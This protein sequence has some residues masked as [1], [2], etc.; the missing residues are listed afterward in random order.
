MLPE[1][2]LGTWK[3]KGG[4]EPLRRGIEL[5][6]FHIDTAEMYSTEGVVGEAVRG[7]RDKVFV[8]SKVLG[9]HLRYDEVLRAA[10]AGLERAGLEYFDLYQI[11]YPNRGV[12]IEETMRAMEALVDSGKVRYI[13]VSNFSV[14]ELREAQAAM[15]RHPVVA[16][17]VIYNLKRRGI[18]SDLMPYCEENDVTV[19]AYTP[20]AGGSLRQGSRLWGGRGTQ[21]LERIAAEVDKTPA[22]VALNWCTTRANVVA[23]PKSNSVARTEENCRASGWRLSPEQ[24]RLLDEAFPL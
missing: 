20:L 17:Q 10:D 16:N 14:D 3:Y 19:V 9:S 5:G 12:P 8:A 4:V 1:I 13:G 11:H 15:T 6:A 24:N 22:Q 7:I 21:T 23:I 2:G 18:E